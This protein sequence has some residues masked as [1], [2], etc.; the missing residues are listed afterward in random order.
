M[1]HN[2][3]LPDAPNIALP[4]IARC[5]QFLAL[6]L[7]KYNYDPKLV[8]QLEALFF[9][10]KNELAGRRTRAFVMDYLSEIE[11]DTQAAEAA[12]DAS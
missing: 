5:A 4:S 6:E 10:V 9:E 2:T 3:F 1:N 11:A 8:E 7:D 12:K